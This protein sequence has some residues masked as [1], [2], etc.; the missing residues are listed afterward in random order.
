MI[1]LV[2]VALLLLSG[3]VGMMADQE[4]LARREACRGDLFAST[5]AWASHNRNRLAAMEIGA[6]RSLDVTEFGLKYAAC[7]VILDR[8]TEGEIHLM[9]EVC[10]DE[11]GRPR[12]KELTLEVEGLP[13][14]PDIEAVPA[15]PNSVA[16]DTPAAIEKPADPNTIT[17]EHSADPNGL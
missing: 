6:A 2:G 4:R 15:D 7:T 10:V 8:V 13:A 9:V 11:R 1:P 5:A 12:R 16:V 3:G 14:R 17:P